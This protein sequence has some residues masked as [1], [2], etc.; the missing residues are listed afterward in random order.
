MKTIRFGII[1]CGLMG[2]EFASGAARWCHL[3]HFME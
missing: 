2:R 1:G 3:Q